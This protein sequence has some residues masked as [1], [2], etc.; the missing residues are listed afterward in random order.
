MAKLKPGDP[1]PDFALNDQRDKTVKLRDFRGKRL[2]VYFY[3]RADT[4]GC[5]TQSCALRDAHP[6]LKKLKTAVV[7]ISPDASAKQKKFDDKYGLGFPLLADEDHK[8]SRA[9]GVWGNKTMYGRQFKGIIRSAF[10]V[11]EKGKVADAFYKVSPKDTVLKVTAA[12][13]E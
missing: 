9:W 3:P 8:V 10:V 5:T 11:D 4:P 7:G 12:L 13:E 6:G 1:A 2:V